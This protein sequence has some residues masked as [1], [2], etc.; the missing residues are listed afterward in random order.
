[1]MLSTGHLISCSLQMD[2]SVNHGC[3]GENITQEYSPLAF[4]T[5][6][7]H[8]DLQYYILLYHDGHSIELDYLFSGFFFL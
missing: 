6:D 5:A 1:M 3:S 7:K 2:K 4:A 8:T